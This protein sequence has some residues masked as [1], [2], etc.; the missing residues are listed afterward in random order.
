MISIANL[1]ALL[2][3]FKPGFLIKIKNHKLVT[4]YYLTYLHSQEE[5]Q[6]V[7][8]FIEEEYDFDSEQTTT[9]TKINLLF[10]DLT[11]KDLMEY[12]QNDRKFQDQI[13][14]IKHE[15]S[16]EKYRKVNEEFCLQLK[17]LSSQMMKNERGQLLQQNLVSLQYLFQV[18]ENKI[19]T[20]SLKIGNG[21]Y[22]AMKNI[23]DFYQAIN[24]EWFLSYG[25]QF[26]FV[27]RLENFQIEDQKMIELI[28]EIVDVNS[29]EKEIK[30]TPN[31]LK[32]LLEA[33]KGR[34]IFLNDAN[35]FVRL[36]EI[37]VENYVDKDY[38]LHSSIPQEAWLIKADQSLYIADTKNLVLDKIKCRACHMDLIYFF[39]K[40]ENFNLKPVLKEFNEDFY[41]CYQ[42]LIQIDPLIKNDFNPNGVEIDSYFD[43]EQ[44]IITLKT[45][46]KKSNREVTED[47]L[48]DYYDKKKHQQY[49]QA[50]EALGFDDGK[51]INEE[52]VYMF[53]TTDLS[54]LRGISTIYLSENIKSKQIVKF[55]PPILKVQYQNNLLSFLFENVHYSDEELHNLLQAI[56]KKHKFYILNK[57]TIVDLTDKNAEQFTEMVDELELNDKEL[58]KET[59]KPLYQSFKLSHYDS[60][61][62][63]DKHVAK[64]IQDIANFKNMQVDLPPLNATL[65]TYQIEGYYWLKILSK[66]NLGGILADDMGL[67]KSL[68]IIALLK[69]DETNMPSLIIC[70]K[71]LIF[72]WRSEFEKFD[73]QTNIIEIY[74]TQSD[75]KKIIDKIQNDQK[76]IYI[77][78]YD[79]LRNDKYLFHQ[80]FNYVII[81]E[82]QFIKNVHA[83][84][85][86][87]VKQIQA[88]HKF[89]LTGTPIENNL[90]DLWS[91]FDF[92]MPNYLPNLSSFKEIMNQE[93]YLRKKIAPFILRR[94]KREVL[95]DLPNKYERIITAELTS[96]Q[97]KLY[98]AL[99][100]ETRDVL[101]QQQSFMNVLPLITR[102]RQIC[103]DPHMFVEN[104]TGTSGKIEAL[105]ELI[106]EYIEN[107]HRLIVFSQFATALDIVESHLNNAQ[108][109]SYKLTGTVSYKERKRLV[110]EFNENDTKVFL[111]TLKT[112]G[113]GFNLIG[114][115]VVVLL[116]PWWNA[117]AEMQAADR[118]Y[119]LGQKKNVEVI[120][121]ICHDSIEQRV[122]ELQNRKKDLID[123]LISNDDSSITKL[124]REDLEFILK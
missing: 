51:L 68:E 22:F 73:P 15:Y 119:R 10:P 104:Y 38:R 117:A 35:Y 4:F 20:L 49:C 27:H 84:K 41:M 24:N 71:S 114:A 25:K 75:R 77:T 16:E 32:I 58:T 14:Q 72:N 47:T 29:C 52:E 109:L 11:E 113:V 62:S 46:Y 3:Y 40:Y 19:Y 112:G 54:Y 69:S 122:I 59:T 111:A 50:I 64:I 80:V 39:H 8:M 26:S 103:I 120:K 102:L 9:N 96:D 5:K 61:V 6:F 1:E 93:E 17:Q 124:S 74:G 30:L 83:Q 57:N 12:I 115:D 55:Q 89:A 18:V 94:T 85:T 100:L 116:D 67:G 123:K 90:Y 48:T 13:K 36:N 79:S 56:R 110:T 66:Y 92:I 2:Q 105:M 23:K 97:Q 87:S 86:K 70:P 44:N 60:N 78:S 81:D 21:R 107:G 106:Q 108:I 88:I 82:A 101:N 118:V 33:L 37:R 42:D 53:L 76:K 91:I 31:T 43:H 34:N 99:V 7:A 45:I 63:I 95:S 98:E 28:K 121:L 65:R